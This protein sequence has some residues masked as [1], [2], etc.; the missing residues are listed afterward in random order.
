MRNSSVKRRWRA[1]AI[2]SQSVQALT[3]QKKHELSAAANRWIFVTPARMFLPLLSLNRLL[4]AVMLSS[5][6]WNLLTYNKSLDRSHRRELLIK[7][8][9]FYHGRVLTGG[10]PVNSTV[11]SHL[12]TKLGTRNPDSYSSQWLECRRRDVL[13]WTVFLT[14]M[15]GVVVI[16][17]PLSRLFHSDY[18]IGIVAIAWM[19]AFAVTHLYRTF[20]KCPRCHKPFFHKFWYQNIFAKQMRAL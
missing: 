4:P 3:N 20:W 14:Y 18:V 16:G 13:F 7:L 1:S 10:G 8:I 2:S 5:G 9:R 12:S 19:V 15:P 11:M 6:T 17:V